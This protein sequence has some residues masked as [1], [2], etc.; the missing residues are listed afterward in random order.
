M[1]VDSG[2]DAGRTPL[3]FA[4]EHGQE[5]VV[6]LLL[7]QGGVDIGSKDSEGSNS[8][9][10]AAQNNHFGVVTLIQKHEGLID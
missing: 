7:E 4:A 5:A 6:K 10:Y 8:L 2:D 1:D 9:H 3:S